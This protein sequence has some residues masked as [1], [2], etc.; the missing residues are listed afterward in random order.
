VAGDTNIVSWTVDGTRYDVDLAD[1][2]GIEWRDI[3]R[4]TGL[5]QTAT[6][7]QALIAKEFDCIAAFLWIW[8]RRT[9]P[10]LTYEAVL[11][12]LKYRTFEKNEDEATSP[13]D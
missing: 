2:D 10:D 12:S 9:D 8:R 6:L 1:I 5:L 13:P 3:T 11:R 4:T 7:T